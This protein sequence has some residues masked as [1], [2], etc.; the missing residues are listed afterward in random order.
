VSK[1]TKRRVAAL[2]RAVAHVEAAL[3]SVEDELADPDCWST[4]ERSAE[5]TERHRA[6]RE[7]V[8]KLYAELTSWTQASA[9][10]PSGC[11]GGCDAVGSARPKGGDTAIRLRSTLL[12][13]CLA[14]LVLVTPAHAV[15]PGQNGKLA[16]TSS[17]DGNGEIYV[18][19]PDGSGPL[20]ITNNDASD[21]SPAWSP[22]G[23]RIAFTRGGASSSSQE[24][25]VMNADGSGQLNLT[26]SAATKDSGPSWSPDGTKIAFSSCCRGGSFF[27]IYSMNADGTGLTQLTHGELQE[28]FDPSWSPDG[29][30]IAV[31]GS[32]LDNASPLGQVHVMDADGTNLRQLTH[33]SGSAY[34]PSWSPDG[35]KLVYSKE[36]EIPD[37]GGFTCCPEIYV[38]DADG[39]NETRLT[40]INEPNDGN[41]NNV[42]ATFSPDGTKIA[43]S[44]C[45]SEGFSINNIYLMNSDGSSLTRIT[46]DGKDYEADWQRIVNRSPDC[47]GV[48][49]SRPVLRNANHRLVAITLEGTTD[50]DGDPVSL[51]VDAVTQDEPVTSR[52]DRTSPDAIDQGDGELRV[53]AERDPR[54]DGRVYRIAFTASDGRG[55]SCSDTVNLAVPTKKRKPA[56]DSAPPSYDSF[57]R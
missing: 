44:S 12:A 13:A 43:F 34:L 3:I 19:N 26:Q 14:A 41:G 42:G 55:G 11:S 15:F 47:S 32:D 35:A 33:G 4:P 49:A 53:R 37:S 23:T 27:E 54:G 38:I 36:S 8:D 28:V 10:R 30:R 45:C 29:T 16:V 46:S 18:M 52:V 48:V 50:P 9:G 22:D 57:A 21:A 31:W 5:S 25:Y 7:T 24:I 51:T 39:T 1:N 2:E 6:A 56:V 17:R 20:N 40:Y